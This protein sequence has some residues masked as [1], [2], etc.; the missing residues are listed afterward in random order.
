MIER[1]I[2][3]HADPLVHP[4]DLEQMAG[5]ARGDQGQAAPA[6]RET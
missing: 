5:L 6:A 4:I 1:L 2:H 3:R